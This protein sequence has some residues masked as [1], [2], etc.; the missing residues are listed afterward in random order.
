MKK[1]LLIGAGIGVGVIIGIL[2]SYQIQ[3]SVFKTAYERV[4]LGFK[5]WEGAEAADAYK[6]GNAETARF[7]LLHFA[8]VLE[9][10]YN[11]KDKDD[12]PEATAQD[13]AFSYVR[14]GKLAQIQG[15]QKEAEEYFSKGFGVYKKFKE[16]MGKDASREKLISL[17]EKLDA[18]YKVE[19]LMFGEAI[20]GNG[21]GGQ[22]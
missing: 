7:T 13:L 17:V 10:F 8:K 16:S 9:F 2:I 4:T 18:S 21:S 5:A 19:P 22:K 1:T 20:S 11:N 3:K 12:S 6:T 15:N 14:L